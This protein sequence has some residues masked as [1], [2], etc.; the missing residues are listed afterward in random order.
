MEISHKLQHFLLSIG[1][2]K[3]I[4]DFC[5]EIISASEL[6]SFLLVVMEDR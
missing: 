4:L 3:H 1:E 5:D 6:T 2:T